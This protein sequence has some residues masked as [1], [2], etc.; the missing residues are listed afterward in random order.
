M[1]EVEMEEFL[2]PLSKHWQRF[3]R[4]FAEIEEIKVSKWRPVHQL[5]YFSMR[6]EQHF[7]KRFAFSLRGAPTKCTEIVFIKK[8]GAMLGTTNQRTVKN[9]I[10]WVFD[11]K[12][13]PQRKRIRSLAFFMAPGL[14][15]EF[16]LQ[17]QAESVIGRST[18]LPREFVE[19]AFEAGI[20]IETY[21][22]LAFIKQALDQSTEGRENYQA[23]YR[24]LLM[25]GLEPDILLKLR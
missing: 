6:Y 13:I 1:A 7:G 9:Y 12:I 3:F 19:L 8:I 17:R 4:K 16:N 5:A 11:K 25:A 23:L 21:G 24:K 10:D 18:A 14:G 2:K 20:P 15:N 22:E